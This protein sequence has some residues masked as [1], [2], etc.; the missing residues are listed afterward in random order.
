MLQGFLAA[1]DAYTHRYDEI[2][3]NIP[4]NVK[5]VDDTLLYDSSIEEPFNHTWDFL[6]LCAEKGIV[7]NADKFQFC[8]DTVTFAGLTITPTS[9]TPSNNLLS[10]IKRFSTPK[11]ITGA[12]SWFGLVNQVSWAYSISSIMQLFRDLVK[13]NST[14]MKL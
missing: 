9:I 3:K 4:R 8:R 1:G 10:A 7:I 6:T 2:I 12:R 14:G 11:D 5:C 13:P